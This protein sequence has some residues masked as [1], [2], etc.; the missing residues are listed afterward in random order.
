MK[1]DWWSRRSARDRRCY[2]ASPSRRARWLP[3]NPVRGDR[4]SA[5]LVAFAAMAVLLTLTVGAVYVGA[6][7]IGRHRAQAAADLAA[8]AAATFLVDGS[9]AAC[10]RATE[11]AMAMH[12]RVSRCAVED[13]DVVVAVDVDVAVGRLA[14]GPAR[15]VARAGPVDADAFRNQ[16]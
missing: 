5:T 3:R 4:G 12:A 13:L 9:A 10:T 6:A 1:A 14:V 8:V 11:V 7:V 15:A 16:R 2:R